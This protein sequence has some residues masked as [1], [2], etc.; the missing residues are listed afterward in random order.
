MK[1][2]NNIGNRTRDLP[3]CSAVPQPTVP[4]VACPSR[5]KI[6]K[7]IPNIPRDI[8][9]IFVRQLSVL[10]QSTNCF[11]C[12]LVSERSVYLQFPLDITNYFR[13]SSMEESL[14]HEGHESGLFSMGSFCVKICYTRS[15]RT[16]TQYL[17]QK[18]T[19]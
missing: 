10:E 2:S 12:C 8:T 1:N 16:N 5:L 18:L 4:L 9:V 6:P 11:Y 19:L 3:A 7:Q 14:G 15:Y 13:C 17:G